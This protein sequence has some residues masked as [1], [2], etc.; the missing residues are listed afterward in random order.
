MYKNMLPLGTVVL[1]KE[2]QKRLMICGRIITRAGEEKIYDY[3]GCYY[4]EGIVNTKSMYFFDKEAIDRVFFLGYKD[5]EEQNYNQGVLGKLGELTV[6]DGKIV[7][8]EK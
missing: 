6:E 2:G 3:C 1:L 8:K 7:Q 4:P 5:L